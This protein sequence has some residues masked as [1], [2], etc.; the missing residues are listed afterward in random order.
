MIFRKTKAAPPLV[1]EPSTL[2]PHTPGSDPSYLG[3]DTAVEGNVT[4]DGEIHID[5]ELRG[6]IQAHTCLVDVNG[7]VQ[8]AI[9]AQ[10]VVV[11]G[12]VV[13]PITAHQLTIVKGGHVEGDVVHQGLSIEQ[14]AFVMGTI[15][16]QPVS[17]EPP[18]LRHSELV[19]P[20]ELDDLPEVAPF[21][22]L[23]SKS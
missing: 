2:T 5:C 23:K 7:H 11:R 16:Q 4:C 13:G 6:S 18:H 10:F 8:G 21:L 22:P 12:R 14:G 1:A 15:T 19:R 9:S 3:P 17:E 20:L